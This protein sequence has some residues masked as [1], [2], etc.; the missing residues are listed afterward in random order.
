MQFIS[1][2]GL[3]TLLF[4][5]WLLSYHKK[6]IKFRTV[7]WGLGL[8]FLFA[9]IILRKDYWSFIG[10]TILALLFIIYIFREKTITSN[11]LIDSVSII[12]SSLIIGVGI[13]FI[14]NWISYT[15]LLVI[16]IVLMILNSKLL[17]KEFLK[18]ILNSILI[19]VLFAGL[20]HK[21]LT[22]QIV[23]QIFSDGVA[24]FLDLSFYG[25]KFLFGNLV[26]G[27]YF[28]PS[29]GSWPG[30]GFQFA[31]KV[32]P[33]IIFF[34]GF[35][36]ILYYL[37]IMQKVIIT[38]AQFMRWTLQTSGA[39][40]LSCSANIFVGQTEAPLLIKPFLNTMTKSELLTIM[41][42]GFA[43]I[44]GGVLA[45]YIAMGVSA[46]HLV[47]ASVMSAPAALVIGKIIYPETEHSATAG[48][49]SLPEIKEAQNILDAASS[50]ISDG[51]KL[52]VNVGA[53]LIGF[54]ALISVVDVIFNKVDFLIDG[55]MLGGE[56]IKYTTGGGISPITQEYAGFFPG[57]LKTL[58]G[59]ILRPLAFLM[60][61]PW[62]DADL[63][64]NLLGIKLSLNEFVA[65]GNL[66]TYIQSNAM[67]ERAQIISTYALCGFANFASIGIQIGGI[68]AVAPSRKKDLS[69]TVFKAMLGGAIASWTTATIA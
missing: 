52:A 45:G 27:K 64:G 57:S 58:F 21:G 38:M 4:I 30:F 67:G 35:M 18:P 49:V 26:E 42:G 13:Y 55:K 9:V 15:L 66:G 56:L 46:G 25:A 29:D 23:F 6:K 39:E 20:I 34:G 5:A 31:F 10:M 17:K 59:T 14:L 51:L 69:Q 32:L 28:F 19:I 50:G 53:M 68:S 16:M 60:G 1:L 8:Q 36:S 12:L 24:N 3:L 37:G 33:T 62:E 47:A 40:S 65:Y 61:V 44:A 41:V 63:V 11:K 48:D 43:T 54:I 2:I 7:I 22:G